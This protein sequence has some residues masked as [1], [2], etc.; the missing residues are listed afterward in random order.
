MPEAKRAARWNGSSM[1]AKARLLLGGNARIQP[2]DNLNHAK[3]RW[4][5][6]PANTTRIRQ[7]GTVFV[8]VADQDRALKFYL[9]KLGFE[10]RA[11]FPYGEGSRCFGVIRCHLTTLRSRKTSKLASRATIAA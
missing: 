8:P 9:D 6:D 2:L 11:D 7:V 5:T 4:M 10:K 3:E 1:S